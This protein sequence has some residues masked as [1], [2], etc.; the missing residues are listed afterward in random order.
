MSR[1][2]AAARARPAGAPG[3]LEQAASVPPA[4]GPIVAERRPVIRELGHR[5]APHRPP[6]P[7][8]PPRPG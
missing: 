3:R 2:T 1:C 6:R 7:P 8:R 5:A 4:R